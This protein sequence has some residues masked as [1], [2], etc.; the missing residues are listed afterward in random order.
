MSRMA[1]LCTAAG[2]MA[3]VV[4]AGVA[5]PHANASGQY[6][7]GSVPT[8]P[9]E[10][11]RRAD[12]YRTGRIGGTELLAGVTD[13][14]VSVGDVPRPRGS[15]E[16]RYGTG[17]LLLPDN[18]LVHRGDREG[19][20]GTIKVSPDRSTAVTVVWNAEPPDNFRAANQLLGI[21]AK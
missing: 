11:V 2:T 10:T 17:V 20:H 21:R 8:T 15:E 3:V 12:N 16:G 4:P 18:S 7:D 5:N 6:G 1:S 19:L 14:A 13:G 9:G